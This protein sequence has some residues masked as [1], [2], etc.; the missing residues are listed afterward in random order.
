MC[1]VRARIPARKKKFKQLT[2]KFNLLFRVTAAY[3]EEDKDSEYRT[4]QLFRIFRF[5]QQLV[6]HTAKDSYVDC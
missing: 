6:P 3:K 5:L 2:P 1:E 4:N